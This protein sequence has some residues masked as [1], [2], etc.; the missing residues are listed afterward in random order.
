MKIV[1]KELFVEVIK[2]SDKIIIPRKKGVIL[3]VF[4]VHYDSDNGGFEHID[5]IKAL[6]EDFETD[7]MRKGA[8]FKLVRDHYKK[9]HGLEG[10]TL[11]TEIVRYID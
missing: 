4:R 10:V 7:S 2:M 8:F 11:V 9:K 1:N 3:K 6:Y 5:T